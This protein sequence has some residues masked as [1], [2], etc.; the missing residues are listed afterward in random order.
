MDT[1]GSTPPR[2]RAHR[3][4]P[5]ADCRRSLAAA[6][7]DGDS[8]SAVLNTHAP[9]TRSLRWTDT[10]S[11]RTGAPERG[12]WIVWILPTTTGATTGMS[13]TVVITP[14][15]FFEREWRLRARREALPDLG[16]LRREPS[17]TATSNGTSDTDRRYSPDGSL[18]PPPSPHLG[19]IPH[20]RLPQG[21][22]V[23]QVMA[24]TSDLS[25]WSQVVIR[26]SSVNVRSGSQRTRSRC[27]SIGRFHVRT[28][29]A[30][31]GWAGS[32][33]SRRLSQ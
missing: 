17:G 6:S 2:S 10:F 5:S 25:P 31:H 18:T 11:I 7:S 23:L 22:V 24:V 33:S 3:S 14:S 30:L 8:L 4:K 9:P 15:H 27:A 28:D 13:T 16:V 32:C 1:P 26:E 20:E 19:A 12:R 29:A 21:P